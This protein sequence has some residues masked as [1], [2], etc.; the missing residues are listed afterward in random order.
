VAGEFSGRSTQTDD[1]LSDA[2]RWALSDED[3]ADLR[4][5]LSESAGLGGRAVWAMHRRALALL[6]AAGTQW[7]TRLAPGERGLVTRFTGLDYAAAR[8]AWDALGLTVTPADWRRLM[9]LEAA[10]VAA[11]N[12]E[13]YVA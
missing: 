10:A 12:G 3:K 4:D 9:V 5:A 8:V 11:L 13:T 2:D 7:R 1:A 6:D